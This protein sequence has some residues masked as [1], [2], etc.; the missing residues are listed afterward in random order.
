MQFMT[1]SIHPALEGH[2][3]LAQGGAKGQQSRS[4]TLGQ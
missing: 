2:R 4:G 3:L 1:Q